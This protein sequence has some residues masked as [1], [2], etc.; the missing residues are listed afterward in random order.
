MCVQRAFPSFL[1]SFTYFTSRQISANERLLYFVS[2]ES[3]LSVWSLNRGR[4]GNG[5]VFGYHRIAGCV[6]CNATG[7]ME[8]NRGPS[9]HL[10]PLSCSNSNASSFAILVALSDVVVFV[11]VL[12]TE[13]IGS[14]CI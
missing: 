9:H 13:W 10:V 3:P 12:D 14:V 6:P 5:A 1:L 2:L 8:T 4:R 7:G 11:C